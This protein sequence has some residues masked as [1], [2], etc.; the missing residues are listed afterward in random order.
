MKST[1]QQL[2][3][4]EWVITFK[5]VGNSIRHKSVN[6]S[7]CCQFIFI[8]ATNV[9]GVLYSVLVLQYSIKFPLQFFFTFISLKREY[10]CEGRVEN[11]VLRIAVWHHEACRLMTNGDPEGQIFYP[12]LT[13][14]M[15]Y[16]SCSP[17]FYY[18]CIYLFIYFKIS[19][20][21]SLNTLRCNFT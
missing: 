21:N 15:D 13:Q 17:L 6:L 1:T 10:E 5:T 8:A 11:S 16:F 20:Q 12:T 4:W 7:C 9:C 2:S 14:I 3:N 18:L 19:F